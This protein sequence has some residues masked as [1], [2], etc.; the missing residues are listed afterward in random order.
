LAEKPNP[1]W[2]KRGGDMAKEK[3]DT[4]PRSGYLEALLQSCP[5]AIISIDAEGTIRFANNAACELLVCEMKDLTGKN[6]VIVYE[7]EERAM[8]ANQKL[9]QSGGV[10]HD[11]ETVA[12]TKTGKLI[13]IRLS[14]A[15]MY[16][17]SGNYTGGVGFFQA[18]RPWTAQ[19]TRLQDRLAE[20]EARLAEWQDLG[21][22]V[23]EFYPGLSM[24]AVVGR[25]DSERF[26][27]LK[28]SI[29][30]HIKVNKT[31]VTL[32]DLSAAVAGGDSDVA[33]QLVKLIRM[34]RVVGAECVIVGIQSTRMVEAIESLVVDVSSLNTFSSLQ[35]GMEAAMAMLNLEISR[36][37][38]E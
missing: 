14:A 33:A 6:I 7:N 13:P 23:F 31:R 20:L 17:S 8:E 1:T 15:H 35:V 27:Q 2:N 36:Q 5:D 19:E 11:H 25:V 28:T 30:N 29:L 12:K 4:K 10:I 34:I 32:I 21:A 26:A 37:Q 38:C 22:P 18:Y 24:A 16:D 3:L 9:Y